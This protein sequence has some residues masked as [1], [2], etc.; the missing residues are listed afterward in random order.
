VKKPTRP[1]KKI[2]GNMQVRI[3]ELILTCHDRITPLYTKRYVLDQA[4]PSRIV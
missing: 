4:V 1:E 3:T 2:R